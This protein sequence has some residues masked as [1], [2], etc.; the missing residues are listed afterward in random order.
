MSRNP[1][2]PL[3]LP[4]DLRAILE[5][6][7]SKNERS[8]N[9]ELVQRLKTTV[10]FERYFCVDFDELDTKLIGYMKDSHEL[11]A[12]KEEHSIVLQKLKA[13]QDEMSSSFAMTGA[14]R[15]EIALMK[16]RKAYAHISSGLDEIKNLIPE[17]KKTT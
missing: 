10:D 2:Y 15:S 7:A 3:R 13:L 4:D 14:G 1:S 12:L 16:L 9:G 17:D 8:L 6:E 11:A 5:A